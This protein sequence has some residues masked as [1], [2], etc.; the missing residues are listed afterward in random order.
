M[1]KSFK[2]VLPALVILVATPAFAMEAKFWFNDSDQEKVVLQFDNG[3]Q[4]GMSNVYGPMPEGCRGDNVT[5]LRDNNADARY[6]N[7]PIGDYSAI[8]NVLAD[9]NAQGSQWTDA[10]FWECGRRTWLVCLRSV[11]GGACGVVHTDD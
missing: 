9:S 6:R 10:N 7:L 2:C 8:R 1:L 5:F 11:G 4:F 3:D